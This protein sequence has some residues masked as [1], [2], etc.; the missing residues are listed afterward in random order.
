MSSVVLYSTV[1]LGAM[2]LALGF[3][4]AVFSRIF[5]VRLDPRIEAVSD[6]LAGLNCGVCGY[7][8]CASFAEAIV[9]GEA[10]ADRGAPGGRQTGHKNAAILGGGGGLA[11]T[12]G[13]AGPG[14]GGGGG[15]G[16]RGG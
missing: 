1:V 11:G 7:P 9:A 10:A 5:A 3:L 15:G 8:G 12:V 13:A 16:G 6:A 2:G 14:G 4:L